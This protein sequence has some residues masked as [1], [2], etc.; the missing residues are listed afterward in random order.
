MVGSAPRG[1]SGPLHL[2]RLLNMGRLPGRPLHLRTVSLAFLFTG[3]FRQLTA[4]LVRTAAGLVARASAV[5]T[6]AAHSANPRS[7]PRDVL[8]LSRRVLQSLLERSALVHG[9]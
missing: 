7:L 5:F 1:I 8:L 3:N 9:R 6:G 2:R 4:Q